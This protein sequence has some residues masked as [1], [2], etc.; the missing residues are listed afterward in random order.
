MNKKKKCC[1]FKTDF[2]PYNGLRSGWIGKD[3]KVSF[4]VKC[5]QVWI[6]EP[7]LHF[8]FSQDD[9]HEKKYIW[10]KLMIDGETIEE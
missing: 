8:Y 3:S 6:Y 1:N 7:E 5:G 9:T 2:K 10:K 4:C